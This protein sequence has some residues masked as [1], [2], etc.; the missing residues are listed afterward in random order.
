MANASQ[1]LRATAIGGGVTG[2]LDAGRSSTNDADGD[3]S[4]S[5]Y[6]GGLYSR[7]ERRIGEE[8]NVITSPLYILAWNKFHIG[9]AW[10]HCQA[11]FPL[12]F[13]VRRS[14][15]RSRF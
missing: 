8:I 10:L 2:R 11:F 1:G 7:D 3:I 12:R 15:Q 14:L 6:R 9:R 5:T 4:P 13:H